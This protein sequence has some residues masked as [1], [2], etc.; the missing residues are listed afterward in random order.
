MTV[1]ALSVRGQCDII[2]A[3]GQIPHLSQN[4]SSPLLSIFH[5]TVLCKIVFE[6]VLLLK[7]PWKPLVWYTDYSYYSAPIAFTLVYPR[8]AANVNISVSKT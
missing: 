4:R 2:F 8:D 7:I 5:I 6:S 1:V 3:P